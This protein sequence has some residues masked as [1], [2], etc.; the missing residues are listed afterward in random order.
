MS[1]PEPG[2]LQAMELGSDGDGVVWA[3][4]TTADRAFPRQIEVSLDLLTRIQ[5][6]EDGEWARG[7]R[8]WLEFDLSNG[9][10]TYRLEVLDLR[11]GVAG[12]RRTGVADFEAVEPAANEPQLTGG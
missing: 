3:R 5:R 6:G 2:D 10:A 4:G 8:G 11:R 9:H 1:W 12:F 7:E